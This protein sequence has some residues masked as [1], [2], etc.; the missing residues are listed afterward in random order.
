[1]PRRA[2]RRWVRQ[3]SLRLVTLSQLAHSSTSLGHS[4]R[5]KRPA[6]SCLLG[7]ARRRRLHRHRHPNPHRRRPVGLRA[8]AAATSTRTL[9]WTCCTATCRQHPWRRATRSRS[10]AGCA[11]ARSAVRGSHSRHRATAGSRAP[12]RRSPS[13]VGS[14]QRP[15]RRRSRQ[16][17]QAR[18]ERQRTRHASWR[19]RVWAWPTRRLRCSSRWSRPPLPPRLP[20]LPLPAAATTRP[21]AAW[22]GPRSW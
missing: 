18:P 10:A 12:S 13:S 8:R 7:P 22:R 16:G 2:M 5:G 20:P 21:P 11:T 19:C 4:P 6:R 15:V 1:M 3:T 9:T 14:S 17:R